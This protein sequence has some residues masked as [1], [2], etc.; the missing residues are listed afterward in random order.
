MSKEFEA[1]SIIIETLSNDKGRVMCRKELDVLIQALERLESIENADPSTALECLE[2]IS[3]EEVLFKN[4]NTIYMGG[5]KSNSFTYK[6][7]IGNHFKEIEE[8][9]Q[10]LLKAQ[11]MEKEITKYK[12]I[13]EQLGCPLEVVERAIKNG[14]YNGVPEYISA[15][16]LVYM[17]G[18][19]YLTCFDENGKPDGSYLIS[20]YKKTWWLKEDRSE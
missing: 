7:T 17:L 6:D 15:V 20:E 10:F 4:R 12:Q 18:R 8:I 1:L 14:I 2:E 19:F 11:E 9:K 3:K 5:E 16:G 13:K